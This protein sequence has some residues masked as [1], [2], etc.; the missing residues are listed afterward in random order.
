MR[1]QKFKLLINAVR[2]IKAFRLLVAH[3]VLLITL[4]APTS[5]ILINMND[6]S[7]E[8]SSQEIRKDVPIIVV[9]AADDKYAMPLAKMARS[10][11][12]SIKEDSSI[13]FYAMCN[14]F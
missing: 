1:H 8:N 14:Y 7:S 11:L 3:G 12:E 4:K 9:C 6:L 5:L 2:E 10:I 13:I